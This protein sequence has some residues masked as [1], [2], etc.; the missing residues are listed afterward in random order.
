MSKTLISPYGSK[1]A[2]LVRIQ[3]WVSPEDR[4]LLRS[5][6]P[7][8]GVEQ[9][10]CAT[11]I[12]TLANFCRVNSLSYSPALATKFREFLTVSIPAAVQAAGHGRLLDESGA[13]KPLRDRIASAE[14]ES[15]NNGEDSSGGRGDTR[16][17]SRKGQKT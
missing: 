15:A 9:Y 7:V 1:T 13:V 12:L 11:T 4:D 3:V 8:P 6:C 5:M 17:R 14:S 16:R 10:L 2:D